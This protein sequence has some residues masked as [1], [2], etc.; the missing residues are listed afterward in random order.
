MCNISLSS[1]IYNLVR[2]Y[3]SLAR[4][5]FPDDLPRFSAPPRCARVALG[6]CGS[7]RIEFDFNSTA[8]L[9]KLAGLRAIGWFDDSW[10]YLLEAP[11]NAPEYIM[12]LTCN[13]A[14]KFVLLEGDFTR[15]WAS[16]VRARSVRSRNP[17][18]ST[19]RLARRHSSS[20][21]STSFLVL[22]RVARRLLRCRRLTRA[23][24]SSSSLITIRPYASLVTLS[25]SHV[26]KSRVASMR[27]PGSTLTARTP[28]IGAFWTIF[29]GVDV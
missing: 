4:E 2:S 14:D 21:S 7:I 10:P 25:H 13:S 12:A 5:V 24:M 18:R 28:Y 9:L 26:W 19:S 8:G 22:L 23:N 3:A 16:Y 1:A 20:S 11:G 29:G 6:F 27:L 15:H 17:S